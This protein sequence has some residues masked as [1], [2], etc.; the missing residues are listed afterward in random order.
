[1]NQLSNNLPPRDHNGPPLVDPEIIAQTKAKVEDFAASAG[2]WL[3]VGQ[4]ASAEQAGELADYIAGARQVWKRVD[5]A[6]VAAKKPHDDAAKAVQGMFTPLLETITRCV[7]KL[8][9]MQADWLRREQARL[10]A[11]RA[12]QR[13]AADAARIAAEEAAA[14]AAST[15][16]ISGE[17]EA[18]R[19]QKQ[20]ADLEKAANR[21][22][23]AN[24][25]SASGGGRTMALRK[26]KKARI[27]DINRL[28][29]HHRERPEVAEVLIRLTEAD[30]RAK[31][32]D[33]TTPPGAEIYEIDSAA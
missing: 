21:E 30:V 5:E 33:G 1:M 19:L 14:I 3:A 31:G 7:D 17:L 15:N 13:R 18:E 32:W 2:E 8:K 10:D 11:E 16:S 26:I 27:T 29:R 6:R 9:P 12:E 28:F 24:V 25:Q 4:I 20:A 22:V 23:R